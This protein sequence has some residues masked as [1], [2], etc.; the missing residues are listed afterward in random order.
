MPLFDLLL[1]DNSACGYE[2]AGRSSLSPMIGLPESGSAAAAARST[3]LLQNPPPIG[4]AAAAESVNSIFSGQR[5]IFSGHTVPSGTGSVLLTEDDAAAV[6]GRALFGEDDCVLVASEALLRADGENALEIES[7]GDSSGYTGEE[8]GPE[9]VCGVEVAGEGGKCVD[10]RDNRLDGRSAVRLL[11]VL[12]RSLRAIS[13]L[14]LSWNELRGGDTGAE[15]AANLPENLVV[16]QL[17]GNPLGDAGVAAL[18]DGL[19]RRPKTLHHLQRIDLA[20]TGISDDAVLAEKLRSFLPLAPKLASLSLAANRGVGNATAIAL[21]NSLN[22]N[23]N[24][25]NNDNIKSPPL[26]HID[27]QQT[28]LNID[29]LI[30]LLDAAASRSANNNNND[31]GLQLG[32]DFRGSTVDIAMGDD[33]AERL[34]KQLQVRPLGLSSFNTVAATASSDFITIQTPTPHMG[35]LFTLHAQ[36]DAAESIAVLLLHL[37]PAATG[38]LAEALIASFWPQVRSKKG[39]IAG[40]AVNLPRP[41]SREWYADAMATMRD[42]HVASGLRQVKMDLPTLDGDAD[43]LRE[44]CAAFAT[45]DKLEILELGLGALPADVISVLGDGGKLNLMKL[46]T[47]VGTRDAVVQTVAL[48]ARMPALKSLAVRVDADDDAE[49][50]SEEEEEKEEEPSEGMVVMANARINS[51]SDEASMTIADELC[52]ILA[53]GNIVEVDLPQRRMRNEDVLRVWKAAQQNKGLVTLNVGHFEETEAMHE[54]YLDLIRALPLLTHAAVP[55]EMLKAVFT[56]L[57]IDMPFFANLA[58]LHPVLHN[59]PFNTDASLASLTSTLGLRPSPTLF[60]PLP[61]SQ[62]AA[63]FFSADLGF[64][65]DATWSLHRDVARLFLP[66]AARD[67]R[68][69]VGVDEERVEQAIVWGEEEEEEDVDVAGGGTGAEEADVDFAAAVS[70][71]RAEIRAKLEAVDVLPGLE[72]SFFLDRYCELEARETTTWRGG[73]LRQYLSTVSAHFR[74]VVS[75]QD[76]DRLLN[77]AVQD[78]F[79]YIDQVRHA[80]DVRPGLDVSWPPEAVAAFLERA[81]EPRSGGEAVQAVCAYFMMLYPQDGR[82]I[83]EIAAEIAR[84]FGLD[85]ALNVTQRGDNEAVVHAAQQIEKKKEEEEEGETRTGGKS[86]LH[87]AAQVEDNH[88]SNPDWAPTPLPPRRLPSYQLLR[89]DSLFFEGIHAQSAKLLW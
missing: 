52:A 38:P 83:P 70:E 72:T 21:A 5:S 32:L 75:R 84:E 26:Q 46:S 65:N 82:G 2:Q 43:V 3:V 13:E 56:A 62:Q 78:T 81:N 48:A 68:E 60:L 45:M 53:K 79:Q 6:V 39:A 40:V 55:D 44:L 54:A 10:L 87:I 74:Q 61:E 80:A 11:G 64:L 67:G 8:A 27:L 7:L 37:F 35:A 12:A 29:G 25:N 49:V 31:N 22:N 9:P 76:A 16:L 77:S 42:A 88:R 24:N 71:I 63:R 18:L 59:S 85:A 47:S 28:R 23:N 15:I 69:R 30:A 34:C 73:N 66:R 20:G 4:A 89:G 86:Y 19:A 36:V 14:D 57:G 41:A 50:T 58:A 33:V 17:G 51:Y 1:P